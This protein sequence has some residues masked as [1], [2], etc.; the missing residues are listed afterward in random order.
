MTVSVAEIFTCQTLCYCLYIH[1]FIT[2][3][4]F[5]GVYEIAEVISQLKTTDWCTRPVMKYKEA[6]LG[7]VA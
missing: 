2:D 1:C 6:Y 4:E 7:Q 5:D 3:I